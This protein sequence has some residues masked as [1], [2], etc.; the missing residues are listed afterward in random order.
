MD[1]LLTI[2]TKEHNEQRQGEAFAP[3]V[4][5]TNEYKKLFYIESYGCAMNFADSEVVYSAKKWF[6]CNTAI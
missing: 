4:L 2:N 1:T 5:D 3:F 6:W